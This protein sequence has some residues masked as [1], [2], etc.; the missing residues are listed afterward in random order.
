[1]DRGKVMD[2]AP[3]KTLLERCDIYR[4]LWDQQTRFIP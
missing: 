2:F 4:H 3:H 1:M